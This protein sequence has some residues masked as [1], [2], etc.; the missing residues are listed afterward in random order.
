MPI[1]VDL[2]HD[3]SRA[4]T[5]PGSSR[6]GNSDNRDP[7]TGG[8]VRELIAESLGDPAEQ[9]ADRLLRQ[10][11][12][13]RTALM[14]KPDDA[15]SGV[16]DGSDDGRLLRGQVRSIGRSTWARSRAARVPSL[17][18]RAPSQGPQ[19]LPSWNTAAVTAAGPALGSA[20]PRDCWSARV[21]SPKLAGGSTVSEASALESQRDR[22]SS[23]R[24]GYGV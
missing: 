5:W 13:D 12:S 7:Q 8:T 2:S 22:S 15:G 3:S 4:S 20:P 17:V 14:G 23:C 21:S 16:V 19:G 1:T 11:R 6:F 24:A 10:R 18:G 9:L